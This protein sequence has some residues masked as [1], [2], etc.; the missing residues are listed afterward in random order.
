MFWEMNFRTLVWALLLALFSYSNADEENTKDCFGGGP[1]D[2]SSDDPDR[3]A[4]A[5][6]K[7]SDPEAWPEETPATEEPYYWDYSVLGRPMFIRIIKNDNR[8]GILEVWLEKE[9]GDQFELFKKYRISYFSG[10]IGPKTKQ[11]DNQAPEGFYFMTRGSLNPNSSYHIS[12]DLGYPN[13]YDRHHGRTGNYLMIHGKSVSIGCFAMTDAS[14]EQIYTLVD[15]ALK[16]GQPFVRVHSFP[17][18]MT[19]ENLENHQGSPH[20]DFWKNLAEGWR[21]FEE[22]NSPPNVELEEGRYV[23]SES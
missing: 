15:A 4:K 11:G 17:F 5:I 18:R 20:H 6:R 13:S 3:A 1:S 22:N 8:D 10:D 16:S 23:F 7:W 14:I 21:W 19:R 2:I 12:M 9:R